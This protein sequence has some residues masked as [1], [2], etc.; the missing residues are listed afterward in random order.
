MRPW[1]RHLV[2]FLITVVV[3]AGVLTP[4]FLSVYPALILNDAHKVVSTGAGRAKVPDNTLYT[5]PELA[6]PE[7]ANGSTWLLGGNQDGLYTVGWLDLTKVPQVLTIPDM[8]TRYHN[9]ELVAPRTGVAIANLKA[10]GQ[11]VIEQPGT[12]GVTIPPGVPILD[13]PGKQVLVIGRTLVEN[14]ADLPAARALAQQISVSP[15]R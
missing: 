10:A 4:V 1:I 13:A 7:T 5:L 15:L 14:D 8:G 9:V 6:S 2:V 11:Y 3:V 12:S